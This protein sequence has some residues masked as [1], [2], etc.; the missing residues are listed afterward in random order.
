MWN[1][2]SKEA[3]WVPVF[4]LVPVAATARPAAVL[5]GNQLSPLPTA[6]SSGEWGRPWAWNREGMVS[7][8]YLCPNFTPTQ[9]TRSC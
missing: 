4:S 8:G 6:Q 1:T 3:L 2:G 5:F 7:K 9:T